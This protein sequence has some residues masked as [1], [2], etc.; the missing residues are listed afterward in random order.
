MIES[1]EQQIEREPA[2]GALLLPS[3]QAA[4][5]G[6]AGEAGGVDDARDLRAGNLFE[7]LKGYGTFGQDVSH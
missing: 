6:H 7:I 3:E 1:S 4:A 2:E 5:V